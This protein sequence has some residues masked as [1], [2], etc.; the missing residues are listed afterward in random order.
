[1][2]LK[3]WG[4]RI[5]LAAMF[6]GVLG[7]QIGNSFS[8]LAQAPT[9]TVTRTRPRPTFTPQPPPTETPAP[10]NT[11]LPKPT[12]T[13]T[14]KPT[15]RPTAVPTKAP[16]P[17]V[18]SAP[19]KPQF[20]YKIVNKGCD[21]SGQ[22]FVQGK[23][24]DVNDTPIWGAIVVMSGGGPDGAW[25]DKY[26]TGQ[27][28]DGAGTPIYSMIVEAFGPATGQ[29]RWVWVVEGTN[30]VSE[31]AEFQFNNLKEDAPGTCW[32]GFADFRAQY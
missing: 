19:P 26:E 14:K 32:R 16:P 7:C 6:I 27:S 25:A 30:R 10:T 22:T 20:K 24:S 31:V 23:V 13:P 18:S 8:F 1:M 28:D 4:A 3:K 12:A 5:A 15:L 17:V 11:P 29:K 21:H 2:Q 9:A